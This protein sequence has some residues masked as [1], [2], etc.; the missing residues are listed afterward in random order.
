V[1]LKKHWYHI[2]LALAEGPAHGAEIR[3]RVMRHTR[4]TLELYPA[5]LYGSVEDLLE[6]GMLREV[7][8]K[9]SRTK[10]ANDRYRY[11]ALTSF[12]REALAAETEEYQE[13]VRLARDLLAKESSA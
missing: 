5:M 10:A 3:R 9:R 4:G 8:E 11:L 1:A 6:N 12:G 13:V 2:L 7:V